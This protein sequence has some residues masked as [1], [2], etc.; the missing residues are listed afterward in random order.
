MPRPLPCALLGLLLLAL[1]ARAQPLSIAVTDFAS[2]GGITQEQMEALSDLV[3]AE[4]RKLGD[5]RV[6]GKEDI[7]SVLGLEEQ[8]LLVGCSDDGCMAE[9]G[10]AL[11]VDRMAAGN[12]SVFDGTYLL[13]LKLIDVKRVLVLRAVSRRIRGDSADLLGEVPGAVAEL[14]GVVQVPAEVDRFELQVQAQLGEALLGGDDPAWWEENGLDRPGVWGQGWVGLGGQAEARGINTGKAWAVGARFGVR[15]AQHH[16]AF[17]QLDYLREHWRGKAEVPIEAGLESWRLSLDR[18]ALRALAGYRFAYP[19]LPWL[20][21]F[22][23]LAVGVAA[24]LPVSVSL[25]GTQSSLS[26]LD[27]DTLVRPVLLLDLGLRFPFAE[28]FFA[29]LSWCFDL[30]LGEVTT[31]GLALAAGAHF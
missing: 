31:G 11:G 17:A 1:P 4:I 12:V 28:R 27:L 19:V 23:E 7:R 10:G 15:F 8:K 18:D 21:P 3:A 2:K 25:A 24:V 13:N 6:I 9:I 5:F 16:L 29:A 26:A 22:A 20:E 30:P 14:L